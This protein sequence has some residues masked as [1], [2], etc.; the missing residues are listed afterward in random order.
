MKKVYSYLYSLPALVIYITLFIIPTILSFFFS[1]TRWTLTEWEFIGFDNFVTFFTRTDLLNSIKNTMIY[2]VLTT[3]LKV[4]IGF[5]VAIFL[6]SRIKNKNYLRAVIL[7]PALISTVAIGAIWKGLMNPMWGP[8][9][10]VLASIGI[11]GPSWLG[12]PRLALYSIIFVDVWAGVGIATAIY[13]AGLLSI[14]PQYY[15]ACE[16]DGANEWQKFIHISLPLARPAMNYVILVAF[17]TNLKNFAL[18][19][20]MTEGGPGFH[21]MLWPRVYISSIAVVIMV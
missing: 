12:D 14:D 17:V 1:L 9:N 13:I 3:S 7:F 18:V 16:T 15:E 2:A 8:I 19:W 6:T 5:F 21:Q 10:Q 4:V 11:Q 20:V